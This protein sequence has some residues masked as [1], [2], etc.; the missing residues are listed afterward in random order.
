MAAVSASFLGLPAGSVRAAAGT[1]PPRPNRHRP[2]CIRREIRGTVLDHFSSSFLQQT[3][4]YA[5][6]AAAAVDHVA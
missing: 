3:N 6:L 4:G 1:E 5:K 2:D